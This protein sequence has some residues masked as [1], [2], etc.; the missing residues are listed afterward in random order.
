[1]YLGLLAI[2]APDL[3]TRGESQAKTG[4]QDQGNYKRPNVR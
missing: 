4:N 3:V 2:V 1:M